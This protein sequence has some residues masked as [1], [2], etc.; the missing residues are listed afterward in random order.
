MLWHDGEAKKS[1]DAFTQLTAGQRD[2]LMKFLN[3]L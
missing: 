3:S 1:R 2:Q